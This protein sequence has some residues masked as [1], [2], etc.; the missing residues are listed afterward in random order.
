MLTAAT[1]NLLFAPMLVSA[2][3]AFIATPLIIRFAPRLKIMD[4][5]KKRSHPATLHKKPI[6]RGGGIPLFLAIFLTSLFFIEPEKRLLGILLGAAV[7]VF[8]GFLDDRRDVHPYWRLVSQFLAA[9]IVVAAG[10]GIAFVTNPLG[11]GIIDL[12]HP[13]FSFELLG[14]TR[15]IWVLSTIFGF[16]W[17]V[18]LMNFVSW[19][20]G[21]D[22]QLSGFTVIAALVIAILSLR[23]SAD[24]TQWPVT[25][26][27]GATAGAYL[28]FLPWHAYP[29]KI[30]PGFGGGTLAGFMLAILAI[31]ANTKV[32]TLL[33]VLSIPITDALFSIARRLFAGKSPVWADREH[34][35]HKLLEAGW[36]RPRVA[37]FYWGATALLGFLALNLSAAGKFYTISGIALL[38]GGVLLWLRSLKQLSQQPGRSSG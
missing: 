20:S 1:T 27:A 35:H 17:I 21:V 22:G 34:L 3:I 11:P 33:V 9:G 4:D 10:I 23:F 30:M 28:G 24:I 25:I 14:E 29:Q 31:L 6:P 36:T 8:V 5:P 18:A 26:L 15:S 2:L 16:F 19:S 37:F 13:R 38:V 12:S 7:I 32:G